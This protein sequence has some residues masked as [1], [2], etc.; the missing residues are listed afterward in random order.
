MSHMGAAVATGRL[1]ATEMRPGAH[2]GDELPSRPVT[3]RDSGTPSSR[4][5]RAWLPAALWAG[6]V[7]G[8]SSIPGKSFPSVSFCFADK[9]VHVG[10]F[11]VL[12]FLCAH[13]VRRTWRLRP[14]A[15]VAV[16]TL[17]ATGYGVIDEYHQLFT[18]FR[19]GAD[20]GDAIADFVGALLGAV[21]LMAWAAL[22]RSPRTDE[23]AAGNA[24]RQPL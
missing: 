13:G 9:L 2:H 12:A 20:L 10:I 16:A 5:W 22:R 14:V 18:P 6:L 24:T 7:F 21:T 8:L 1:R 3:D 19:S 15:T 4:S 17:I 11:A 23:P